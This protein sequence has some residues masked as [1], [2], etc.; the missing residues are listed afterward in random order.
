MGE[1]SGKGEWKHGDVDE[2]E[3]F[4]PWTREESG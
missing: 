3:K 1:A 4:W 2:V